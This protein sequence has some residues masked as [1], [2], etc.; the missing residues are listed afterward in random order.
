MSSI[1]EIKAIVSGT[2]QID[3]RQLSQMLVDT[4]LHNELTDDVLIFIL[5]SAFQVQPRLV[6]PEARLEGAARDSYFAQVSAKSKQDGQGRTLA[7]LLAIDCTGG[8]VESALLLIVSDILRNTVGQASGVDFAQRAMAAIGLKFDFSVNLLNRVSEKISTVL[9]NVAPVFSVLKFLG[10]DLATPNARRQPIFEH[11]AVPM[12]KQLGAAGQT[13]GALALEQFIYNNH[14]K[15]EERPDHHKAAF[16]AIGEP[17]RHLGALEAARLPPMRRPEKH[18]GAPHIAFLLHNGFRLAHVELMLSFF[19]GLALAASKPIHPIV[20]S[21]TDR[22]TDELTAACGKYGVEVIVDRTS[23]TSFDMK[24]RLQRCREKLTELNVDAVAFVSVPMH[25]DY[26]TALKL[27]PISIWWPMKFPLATFPLLDG[28]VMYR[29]LFAGKVEIDGK[30]WRGGPLGV[31]APPPAD[32]AA[33]S[34]V[35]ARF[36]N[37]PII[38]TVAREE[39]IRD[40]GYLEA[41]SQILLANP[42]ANFLWTGRLQLPE[43]SQYF[44]MKGVAS[45]CHFIGW[46][47]PAIYCRVFDVFLETFPLAGLMSGWAMMAGKSVATAGSFGWLGTHLE[48]VFDGT[49]PCN[50][51]DKAK[52]DSVFAEVSGRLPCIWATDVAGYVSLVNTLLADETLRD[53]FGR[54]CKNFMQDFL[55]DDVQSSLIQAK[56][57]ADVTEEIVE[58]RVN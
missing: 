25:L 5:R 39:K 9:P 51:S 57:F 47:D 19:S 26:A 16:S 13:D 14:I 10:L 55:S 15:A 32:P 53:A 7:A 42:T 34:A 33:V 45:R 44:E 46:V 12:M 6:G 36:P 54:A 52:L 50:P 38:G 4:A 31:H 35:R 49:I 24:A 28:R 37:G 40:A 18:L 1:S 3:R 41:V 29:M 20:Y 22:G 27:A 2:A 8:S 21:L 17:L 43:I 11:V 56:H 30:L 23:C 48:G 58:Q